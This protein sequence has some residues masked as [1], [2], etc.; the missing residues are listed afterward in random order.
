MRRL[1]FIMLMA[2]ASVAAEAA[3]SAADSIRALVNLFDLTL[4]EDP[5][6]ADSIADVVFHRALSAGDTLTASSMLAAR[7]D[8]NAN[9][10]D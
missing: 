3:M 5:Y 8:I 9:N 7:A 1:V 10:R 4:A 2:L 6:R